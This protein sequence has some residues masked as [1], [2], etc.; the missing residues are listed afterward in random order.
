ML[1]PWGL[2]GIA[3]AGWA[4]DLAL[5]SCLL[6]AL[7]A[8]FLFFFFLNEVVFLPSIKSP[9]PYTAPHASFN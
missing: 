3:T 6:S 7:G 9:K 5:L 2:A 4:G 1:L 8:P